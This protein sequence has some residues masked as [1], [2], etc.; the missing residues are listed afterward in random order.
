MSKQIPSNSPGPNPRLPSGPRRPFS[1]P[2]FSNL[3]EEVLPYM[4]TVAINVGIVLAMY[5]HK[6]YTMFG[7]FLIGFGVAFIT[8]LFSFPM[9]LNTPLSSVPP[10]KQIHIKVGYA[11]VGT[12]FLQVLLGCFC[13]LLNLCKVPSVV[14]Y[15]MNKIHVVLGYLMTILCKF[16]VYYII[17]QDHVFWMLLAQDC[18][19]FIFTIIK[20]VFFSTPLESV[21]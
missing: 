8:L 6:R 20:K 18:L 17:D 21:G 9:L 3:H 14:L 1:R 2:L 16:Q 15:Y 7:H 12:I 11:I 13:K 10:S 4:W 5:R 19:F